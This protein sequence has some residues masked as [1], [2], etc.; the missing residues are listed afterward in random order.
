MGSQSAGSVRHCIS[1]R[2]EKYQEGLGV[3]TGYSYVCILFV[4][5]LEYRSLRISARIH[6]MYANREFEETMM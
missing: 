2:A 1:I 6:G 4:I 3:D 5:R